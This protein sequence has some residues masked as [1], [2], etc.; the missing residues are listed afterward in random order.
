[1]CISLPAR[2]ASLPTSQTSEAA[3]AGLRGGRGVINQWLTHMNIKNP[4][5]IERLAKFKNLFKIQ[6][7]VVSSGQF[8]PTDW[9][10]GIL[11]DPNITRLVAKEF[12]RIVDME[13]IDVIAGI[14]LQGVALAMATALETNKPMVITRG[15]AK[16][17]GRTLVIGDRNFLFKG[18]RV[19][20]IDDLM[21]Y[22]GTKEESVRLLEGYGAKIT[23]IG[24]FIYAPCVPPSKPLTDDYKFDAQ[25]WLKKQKIKLHSLISYCELGEI[26]AKAGTIPQGLY[27]KFQSHNTDGPYWEDPQN[28]KYLLDYM[29][30]EKIPIQDFVLE[31]AKRQ[32][33]EF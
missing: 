24:V 3:R 26:Q 1:M 10:R 7:T 27:K 14:E 2:P 21:A 15:K 19:L 28:I 5:L 4:E 32:G 17:P 13:K 29:K 22:G 25:D 16:R 30:K 18:A 20:L 12:V 9:S 23:D 33:V 31:H 11:L 8:I 6:P